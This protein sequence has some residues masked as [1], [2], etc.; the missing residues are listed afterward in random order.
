MLL[1]PLPPLNR[2]FS[3]AVQQERQMFADTVEQSKVMVVAGKGGRANS[4]KGNSSKICC[5]CGI[6]GHIVDTCYKKHGF[7]PHLEFTK[8]NQNK[9]QVYVNALVH[10]DNA[11][12]KESRLLKEHLGHQ[13]FGFTEEQ[14][15]GLIALL[16]YSVSNK[17]FDLIHVDL[18]GPYSIPFVHGHKYFLTI[19]DDHSRYTWIFPLKLKS[20]TSKILQNFVS[21]IKTQFDSVIKV[22]RSDNGT[23]FCMNDFYA[24]KGIIHHTSCAYT[25]E[26]NG[27]VE[28]KHGHLLNV[29]RALMLQSNLPKIY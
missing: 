20:E 7:P 15:Q 29:A 8:Q 26:Q 28:R 12:R 1:D 23:E 9:S 10:N 21:L 17:C 14:Y 13:Q 5:H 16:Q 27:I 11:D 24:S 2:V 3:L 18:W 19:V 4:G 6:S 22:I 25:P